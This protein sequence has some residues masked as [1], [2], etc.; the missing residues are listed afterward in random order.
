MPRRK[1]VLITLLLCLFCIAGI[2]QATETEA[3]L[4][5]EADAT[6]ISLLTEGQQEVMAGEEFAVKAAITRHTAGEIKL[7]ALSSA[8]ETLAQSE[9]IAGLVPGASREVFLYG[10]SEKPG[11]K[12]ISQI[13]VVD[14][15][16]EVLETIYVDALLIQVQAKP[17]VENTLSLQLNT[18]AVSP[19]KNNEF[20]LKFTLKNPGTAAAQNV[21]VQFN[22]EQ[23]FVRGSSN[24][25]QFSDI[26]AGA[27]QAIT[28]I[29]G[30]SA[31]NSAVYA[32][33][34]T[35]NCVLPTGE[36]VSLSE[37]ITVTANDLGI[38]LTAPPAGTPRVFLQK[39]TLSAHSILAGDTVKLTLYVQNSSSREVRNL[40][41]SLAA[42]PAEDSTSG[43]VFSPVNSSNSFFVER[44][45]AKSTYTKSIEIYVDPNATAKTYLVPVEILYEDQQGTGYTVSEMVNIPVLQESRLQVLSV[46]VPQLAPLGEPC[47]VTAEFVN[48]GKVALKNLMV[49][50]EGDFPKEN[51][52]FFLAS[53]EIGQSEFYQAYITP[54]TEG[55]LE[56]KVIFTYNDNSNQEVMTEWPFSLEVQQMAMPG[57]GKPEEPLPMDTATKGP[58]YVTILVTLLLLAVLVGVVLWRR[59]LKRGELF[60]EEL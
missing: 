55:P 46:E 16:D 32:I 17:A 5:T 56:G 26:A 2:A 35:I 21:S 53:F 41:I 11:L 39:Y 44:I 47:P 14:S 13:Q 4:P 33:P 6:T 25:V 28:V 45:A 49:T 40:K 12:D 9:L 54:Q 15:Q 18:V 59:R 38:K 31:A 42:I 1:P 60:D 58:S 19:Y 50:L 51:A 20:T 57:T 52:S 24:V 43:T 3:T 30:L 36:K 34:V 23:A 29:M 48:V 10:L 27:S 7:V 8:N 22:G 37:T